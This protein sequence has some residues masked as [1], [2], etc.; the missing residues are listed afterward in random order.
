MR[1][2]TFAVIVARAFLRCALLNEI[3]AKCS[4]FSNTGRVALI[5]LDY[6]TTALNWPGLV[7]RDA[8]CLTHSED[9]YYVRSSGWQPAG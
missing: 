1:H 7:T 2:V 3:K 5:S 9:R 4:C 8:G 6:F